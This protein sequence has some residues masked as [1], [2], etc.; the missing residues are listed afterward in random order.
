[1]RQSDDGVGWEERERGKKKGGGC[2][3]AIACIECLQQKR[4]ERGEVGHMG[5]ACDL[6]LAQ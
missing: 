2:D 3:M 4:P 6:G 5:T 1:M